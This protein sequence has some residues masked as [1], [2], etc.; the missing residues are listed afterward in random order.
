MPE[1]NADIIVTFAGR[2]YREATTV[3]VTYTLA[4]VLL[5]GVLVFGA[6]TG[7]GAMT[8][9]RTDLGNIAPLIGAVVGGLVGYARGAARAFD[10]KLRAQLALCQVEIERNTRQTATG[11]TTSPGAD[12]QTSVLG[13]R[14]RRA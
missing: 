4:G 9:T 2:L 7:Y 3:I 10:L 1:Y 6:I 13:E 5:G 11:P 12:D 8:G 14:S